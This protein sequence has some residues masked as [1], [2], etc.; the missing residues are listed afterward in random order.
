MVDIRREIKH[1]IKADFFLGKIIVILGARQVGKTS[2]IKV[3]SKELNE[4]YLWLDGENSDV[5]EMFQEFNVEKLRTIAKNNKLIVIDEA[6]KI[7]QI[8]SILKIYADYHKDIQVIA[9]GSCAFE[10]RNAMN[11]PLTGRKFEY[12]LYPFTHDEL[13]KHTNSY[14]ENRLLDKRLIYGYYPEVVTSDGREEQLLRF[15]SESYLYKDIFLHKSLKKPEKILDLLKLLAWQIGSEVSINSL[16]NTL[17]IDNET[18]EKYIHLLEQTFVIYKLNAYH[19]N[20]RNELTK[21][22]K[23][24]FNDLG[25]RNAVINDF[26]DT[27]NRSD[28]GGMFENHVINE[29]R[30]QNQYLRK[31]AQMYFWRSTEQ[32]EIDLVLA[33]NGM[34]HAI[35]VK[36][37]EAKKA[38]LTRT[39][40]N[41]YPNHTFQVLNRTNYMDILDLK[42][43]I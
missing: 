37:S 2:L 10:L 8:G 38:K 22:K 9:S 43:I 11:E 1:E 3:L 4:N 6:Q 15:L 14:T 16:S 7:D 41:I 40:S 20:Q 19:T 28:I 31:H 5:R 17:R 42:F 21:S 32:K 27:S 30:K 12:H 25:I 13:S 24:Y 36:W 26:R 29:I 33:K 39:F 18:V 34:L 23:I 35:E